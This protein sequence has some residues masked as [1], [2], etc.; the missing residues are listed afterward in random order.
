MSGRPRS[1]RR[2]PRRQ[3]VRD[4]RGGEHASEIG[5]PLLRRGDR[6]R[7]G[8]LAR[9]EDAHLAGRQRI[10]DREE[11]DAQRRLDRPFKQ[12]ANGALAA[13]LVGEWNQDA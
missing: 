3:P 9:G 4:V 13:G 11:L 6:L 7:L 5:E 1:A 8:A 12:P 2:M 10:D